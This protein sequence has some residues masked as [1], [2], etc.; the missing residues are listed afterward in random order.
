MNVCHVFA[1]GRLWP[2]NYNDDNN[3]NSPD[4][5]LSA[6]SQP[7]NLQCLQSFWETTWN[8]VTI[9]NRPGIF[10]YFDI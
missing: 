8:S 9:L 6:D 7:L 2:S 10:T 5:I 1:E 3:D 4:S